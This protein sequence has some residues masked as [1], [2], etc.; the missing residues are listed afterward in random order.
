MTYQ[1][2]GEDLPLPPTTFQWGERR[3]LGL[4]GNNRAIYGPVYS[5]QLKWDVLTPY[6]LDWL[7]DRWL[8]IASAGSATVSLPQKDAASYVFKTYSS[9]IID[10]PTV[11][12][13]FEKHIVDVSLMI[14]N[15]VI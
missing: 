12:E 1:I 10:E 5:A 3:V 7:R 8:T 4:D 15:I 6:Q 2:N 14:R 11:G 9:V 13:F